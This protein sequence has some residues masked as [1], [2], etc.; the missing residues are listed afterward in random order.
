MPYR[1]LP[2]KE[3]SNLPV[4]ELAIIVAMGMIARAGV[5]PTTKRS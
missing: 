4:I 1:K 5:N 2:R 3:I